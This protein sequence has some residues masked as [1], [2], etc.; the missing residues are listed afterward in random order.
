VHRGGDAG[1]DSL[2]DFVRGIPAMARLDNGSRADGIDA[3]GDPNPPCKAADPTQSRE[4]G[5]LG[6]AASL[7]M[8][9]NV[10]RFGSGRRRPSLDSTDAILF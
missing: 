10:V 9:A 1:R 5:A 2:F 4:N 8:S 7:A 6:G 3:A